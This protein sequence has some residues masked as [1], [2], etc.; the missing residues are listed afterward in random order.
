MLYSNC[1]HVS[2]LKARKRPSGEV[3]TQEALLQGRHRRRLWGVGK[4]D[5]AMRMSEQY[6]EQAP[7][8]GGGRYEVAEL[9]F[10]SFF[11]KGL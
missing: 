1:I 5:G 4:A 3:I 7:R 9:R 10:E 2:L 11:A 8:R 6:Q